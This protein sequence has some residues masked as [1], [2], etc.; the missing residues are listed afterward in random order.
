MH[1]ELVKIVYEK[2]TANLF[3]KNGAK[4]SNLKIGEHL[5]DYFSELNVGYTPRAFTDLF[6]KLKREEEISLSRQDLVQG[7]CQYLGY[8]SFVEFKKVY[9]SEEFKMI[10][11]LRKRLYLVLLPLIALIASFYGINQISSENCMKW[12]NDHYIS[13]DCNEST[14]EIT[15]LDKVAL[16]K[17]K[18][19]NPDCN[20]VYMRADGSENLWYGKGVNGEYEYFTHYGLHPETEKTLK[21]VTKHIFDKYICPK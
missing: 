5:S 13:I 21:K 17:L 15:P 2:A 12:E 14:S 7:L 4:P 19:V 11:K 8:K 16:K 20:Y 6:L 18:K 1:N 10:P 9:N 3:E